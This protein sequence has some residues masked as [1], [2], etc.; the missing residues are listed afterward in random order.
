MAALRG[1]IARPSTYLFTVE[2]RPPPD[3]FSR[4]GS[5]GGESARLIS[6]RS[7]VQVLLDPPE[8]PGR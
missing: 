6:V 2:I 7:E 3:R 1:T 8:T 5:S 4:V